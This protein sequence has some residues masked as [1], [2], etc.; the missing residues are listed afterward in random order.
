MQMVSTGPMTRAGGG[1]GGGGGDGGGCG[2]SGGLR[3]VRVLGD[4]LT[5]E[6]H[7]LRQIPETINFPG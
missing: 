6:Y 5:H 4:K 7:D 1:G 3:L 2:G